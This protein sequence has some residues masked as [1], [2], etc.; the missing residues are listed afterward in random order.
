MGPPGP[1]RSAETETIFSTSEELAEG[2]ADPLGAQAA[3]KEAL[4]RLW[5]RRLVRAAEARSAS[6]SPELVL[7]DPLALAKELNSAIDETVI[8]TY[9]NKKIKQMNLS[10][11]SLTP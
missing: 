9:K 8:Q 1:A 2:L 11:Q 4:V 7:G 10:R 5:S 3:R 6:R